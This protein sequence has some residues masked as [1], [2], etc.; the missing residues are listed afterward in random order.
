MSDNK[1]ILTA[2]TPAAIDL[3]A[4]DLKKAA[5]DINELDQQTYLGIVSTELTPEQR[6]M[7]L[8]PSEVYPRQ[9]ELLAIHWHPEWIPMELIARR[10]EAMFPN[11]EHTA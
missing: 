9:K 10:I 11:V 8:T 1:P 2:C 6:E 5:E 7:V 4:W 3:S